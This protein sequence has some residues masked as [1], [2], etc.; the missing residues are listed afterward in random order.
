MPKASVIVPVYN[1]EAYLEKCVQSI[2]RQTEQD[3]ELLLVDDG[4]TDSSGQLCEELAKKDSRIRVIHQENQGLG[5][6]RN[7]GIREA[8]GDWLL[9]VDSDDWIEPEILEKSLEAGLR[10]EADMV[11]FPFR[12]VDEE[13]R[14]L[15]VFRENV[16]LD[17]ALSL[18]ERKDV[19][20][21]APVAWNKLYRTAFFRETGLAYPS[22]VW[23]EDIRT[24]PKLMALARRMVFLGD[25]G[26]NYLQRQG[27]IMNSGKVA[28]N[29]EIIEAFDDILPWFREHGLF[30][31]YRQELEHLTVAHILLTSSVRVLR[32]DH[33]NP[34]LRKFR[35]YV[36]REFPTYRGNPYNKTHF[37]RNQKIALWLVERRWYGA[38]ALAFRVKGS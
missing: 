31:E 9:L 12:S 7:T 21:T 23:Y 3:F 37:T 17:R 22:R 36:E 20:L 32:M 27:S 6:A 34:L 28:R 1:V 35:A 4:S 33:K 29:V 10:E 24:T 8:K 30:A 26:Y 14:E 13:G 38:A 19:L 18:K 25:I 11:M 2:L 15:A 5:G 16:P